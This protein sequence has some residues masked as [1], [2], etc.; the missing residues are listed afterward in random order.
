MKPDPDET[1]KAPSKTGLEIA[2]ELMRACEPMKD[3]RNLVFG[4][5]YFVTEATDGRFRLSMQTDV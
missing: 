1:M 3:E 4:I 5:M 2:A